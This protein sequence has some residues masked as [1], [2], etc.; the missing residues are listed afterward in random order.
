[1]AKF[2]ITRLEDA[3]RNP[4]QF[5]KSLSS[6]DDEKKFFPR[7]QFADWQRAAI[8]YHDKNDVNAAI[9]K[10]TAAFKN[11]YVESALND[12]KLEDF[13]VKLENY[14]HSCV[15]KG[16]VL[17]ERR[18]RVQIQVHPNLQMTGLIPVIYMNNKN[19]YNA[20][21]FQRDTSRWEEELKYPIIQ[22]HIATVILGCDSKLVEVG[23]YNIA[24][25]SFELKSFNKREIGDAEKEL[26]DLG[27]SINS[28]M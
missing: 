20:C 28:Y 4:Q 13:V 2:S 19:G 16:L 9:K 26:S 22:H 18:K 7:S 10:L 14:A 24:T 25:S 3:R 23:I 15:K 17:S 27:T 11:G 21:F 1:M 8:V 6:T 5:A 12:R